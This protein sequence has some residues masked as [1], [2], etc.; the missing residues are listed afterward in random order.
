VGE[1]P[2]LKYIARKG[3][4]LGLD[5]INLSEKKA[6]D[7]STFFSTILFKNPPRFWAVFVMILTVITIVYFAVVNISKD[8]QYSKNGY[9]AVS[10][11]RIENYDVYS[12]VNISFSAKGKYVSNLDF[13]ELDIPDWLV[14]GEEQYVYNEGSQEVY[15]EISYSGTIDQEKT[16]RFALLA[17]GKR[18][19]DVS[20]CRG[21]DT[22]AQFFYSLSEF[23]LNSAKCDS[24][25]V[26]SRNPLAYDLEGL[27][28]MFE[29]ECLAPASWRQFEEEES[30]FVEQNLAEL[31]KFPEDK[32]LKFS[33]NC[34]GEYMPSKFIIDE[35]IEAIDLDGDVVRFSIETP[36]NFLRVTQDT[37]ETIT[38]EI[39]GQKGRTYHQYL[40]SAIFKGDITQNKIG[41]TIPV[42]IKACDHREQCS[43]INFNIAVLQERSCDFNLPDTGDIEIN[44]SVPNDRQVLRGEDS[45]V[46]EMSGS[47][48]FDVEVNLYRD[49][50]EDLIEHLARLNKLSI[51]PDK[52]YT[53]TWD[54]Q[55][56]ESGDYC[57]GLI[58]SDSLGAGQTAVSDFAKVSVDNLNQ[59]PYITSKPE[60]TSITT[61]EKYE[62]TI[63]AIDLDGDPL[64]FDFIGYPDWL[65]AEG[66]KISGSTV[67]PGTYTFA[68]FVDDN[69]EGYDIEI[70]TINVK[71]PDNH[72]ALIEFIYPLS[73][74]VLKGKTNVVKWGVVD[75]EGIS[76]VELYYSGDGKKWYL[77]GTFPSGTTEKVWDV[78][79]LSN[80]SYYLRLVVTDSSAQKVATSLVSAKFYITNE[81]DEPQGNIDGEDNSVPTI[82]NLT[83][84]PDSQTYSLRPVVS[85]SLAPSNNAKITVD[86][87]EVKLDDKRINDQCDVSQDLVLCE[88][89]EDLEIGKHKVR[90][91]I[92]DTVK[93]SAT[94]EWYFT[95][96][97]KQ[98][99][100]G[101]TE[102]SNSGLGYI[103][104]PWINARIST[105]ILKIS[106]A[107]CCSALALILIP[108]LVY[109]YWNKSSVKKELKHQVLENSP[110]LPQ[111]EVNPNSGW[112]GYKDP[113]QESYPETS[114]GSV[115]QPRDTT[116]QEASDNTKSPPGNFPVNY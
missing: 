9:L 7:L 57:L 46:W 73:N 54:S 44:L 68:A 99:D 20:T 33:K 41:E 37:V 74:S 22:D 105:D 71:P 61:G 15:N 65:Y 8:G 91:K 45:I 2:N 90:I 106:G 12:D 50:C 42:K 97:E 70:V 18:E 111:P 101:D 48:L 93:K 103:E 100:S 1:K 23:N 96:V 82:E 78:S 114:A 66:K 98:E 63:S 49:D 62:Y 55:G 38:K 87:T 47:D 60:K 95:I 84:E 59:A 89:T 69:H 75:D 72:P 4:D 88:I 27:C 109:C 108:W 58:A 86:E 76:K 107:L 56:Y 52:G 116:S 67:I 17:K 29:S 31:K 21:C 43:E 79:S 81:I 110:V 77:L 53:F 16:E 28:T 30:C 32:V 35:T 39:S 85:A 92:K 14:S 94:E 34:E 64:N 51:E 80:G 6:L 40:Y 3:R 112:Q 113:A 11:N 13:V 26:W 24:S 102:D 10:H 115:S 19:I 104:I 83:P 36:D 5:D 25:A